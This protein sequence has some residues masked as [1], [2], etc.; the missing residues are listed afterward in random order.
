MACQVIVHSWTF[1]RLVGAF[2]D[3]AIAYFLLCCSAIA[4]FLSKFLALLGLT[5]PC[6]CN[7]LFGYPTR[8]PCFQR[9]LVDCP[10][11][12]ISSLHFSVKSKFPFDSILSRNDHSQLNLKLLRE[13]YS[14][15]GVLHLEGEAS[16]SSFSDPWRSHHIL[17]GTDSLSKFH[18]KGKTVTTQRS[19]CGIRRRRRASIDYGKFTS[20]SSYDHLKSD[21]RAIRQSPSDSSKIEN[22]ENPTTVNFCGPTQPDS[23]SNDAADESKPV[24]D[25]ATLFENLKNNA[26]ANGEDENV[27]RFL[28]SA[29][30]EE[31]AARAELFS[32]LEQERLAAA[33]A[34]DEAMAMISRLQEEKASIEIE[35]RQYQRI[36]EE[37]SVYD[38]E[39]MDILKEIIVRRE[40]EKHFLE[41]EVEAYRKVFQVNNGWDSQS[42][43]TERQNEVSALDP[44][45]DP[46]L[47]LQQLGQSINNRENVENI[48]YYPDYS[49]V[50]GQKKTSTVSE[51]KESSVHPVDKNELKSLECSSVIPV[52]TDDETNQDI[53]EKGMV[54]MDA[55]S[56]SQEGN[57][58]IYLLQKT[59]CGAGDGKQMP[60]QVVEPR[61]HDV[62]IIDS[63][64]SIN[65]ATDGKEGDPLLIHNNASDAVRQYDLEISRSSSDIF[66][67]FPTVCS[68]PDRSFVSESRCNSISAVDHERLKIDDEICWLRARLRTVQEEKEKLKGSFEH[69][70]R[71]KTELKVLEDI[72]V[73][74]REIR[75]L[76]APEKAARQ[77]SLPPLSS[78]VTSKK[79]RSRGVSVGVG[80]SQSS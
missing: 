20:A 8:A 73:Q 3:L 22:V 36:L 51:G 72:A 26:G 78:K 14:D 39:E 34:A 74:L 9:F 58:N 55:I 2:L 80:Q 63:K 25:Y 67:R 5:L 60:L 29:L 6:P 43:D 54:S 44:S 52:S 49:S 13:G 38:A 71:E 23:E 62:H 28:E 10:A 48:N 70:E 79:R 11:E 50:N 64:H 31:H 41:K 76:T 32:E 77:A 61:V 19:R 65:K 24:Y 56:R 12:T 53:Q 21:S 69:Q 42:N 66:D 59:I 18:I 30:E 15:D 33:S 68:S 4:F 27:V 1:S 57:S 7:G 17:S 47:I 40:R 37:K 75:H 45:V 46:V 35:A 16:Y